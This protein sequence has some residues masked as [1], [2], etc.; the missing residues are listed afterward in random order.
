MPGPV[1][2]AQGNVL[3]P[4]EGQRGRGL[5]T[6]QRQ[7]RLPQPRARQRGREPTGNCS[8]GRRKALRPP[9][10]L[11]RSP[12]SAPSLPPARAFPRATPGPGGRALPRRARLLRDTEPSRAA[13]GQSSRPLPPRPAARCPPIPALHSRHDS[14]D[15]HDPAPQLALPQP[16]VPLRLMAQ[17]GRPPTSQLPPQGS[18]GPRTAR[19]TPAPRSSSELPTHTPRLTSAPAARPARRQKTEAAAASS[20][21]PPG[22]APSAPAPQAQPPAPGGGSRARE[23][24]AGPSPAAPLRRGPSLSARPPG[25]P[26]QGAAPRARP[27]LPCFPPSRPAPAPPSPGPP[28]P[29]GLRLRGGPSPHPG[30]SVRCSRSV[31]GKWRLAAER[32]RSAEPRWRCKH[33]GARP[34]R[35][36]RSPGTRT[37]RARLPGTPHPQV[38]DAAAR[39]ARGPSPGSGGKARGGRSG[40]TGGSLPSG[41]APRRALRPASPP[42]GLRAPPR[43]KTPRPSPL[44]SPH[45]PRRPASPGRA[46]AGAQ[47][48]R[49]S[50]APGGAG[51]AAV[52]PARTPPASPSRPRPAVSLLRPGARRPPSRPPRPV[53]RPGRR[54]RRGGCAVRGGGASRPGR[55]RGRSC[56]GGIPAPA[57]HGRAVPGAAPAERRAGRACCWLLLSLRRSGSAG[58]ACHRLRGGT[59]AGVPPRCLPG[60]YRAPARRRRLPGQGSR[61]GRA[62]RRMS[63]RLGRGEWHQLCLLSPVRAGGGKVAALYC[64]VP[65]KTGAISARYW[66]SLSILGTRHEVL[67]R[68]IPH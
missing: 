10:P 17:R 64:P 41:P 48:A 44:T 36:G 53:P 57:A 62:V 18:A 25:P 12:W 28:P 15:R 9:A 11:L 14:G 6:G 35:P 7:L 67:A 13:G 27:R 66:H 61:A 20:L 2:P 51:G 40:V 34:A 3:R 50:P 23:E 65:G 33:S 46:G 30:P 4:P 22:E 56:A 21:P 52:T 55:L 39:A 45:R 42:A 60:G 19:A 5:R 43:A 16:S 59:R 58:C 38:S 68:C 31:G 54:W 49:A 8:C 24:A 37:L 32:L 1:C 63:A 26:L 29:A 47:P